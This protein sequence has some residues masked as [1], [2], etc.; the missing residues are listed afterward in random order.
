MSDERIVAKRLVPIMDGPNKGDLLDEE[1]GV[2][3]FVEINGT[4]Q[5]LNVNYDSDKRGCSQ[6]YA[7]WITAVFLTLQPNR[8][9]IIYQGHDGCWSLSPSASAIL[10]NMSMLLSVGRK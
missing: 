3:Y 4:A 9:F 8:H 2:V 6:Y 7:H 10:K 1:T 5:K